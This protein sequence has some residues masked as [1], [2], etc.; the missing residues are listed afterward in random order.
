MK[1]YKITNQ[2]VNDLDEIWTYTFENWSVE[3]AD[4]YYS[5]IIEEI[6]YL[7]E[8]PG[9]GTSMDFIKSGYRSSKV[10][11]HLIFYKLGTKKI[12]EVVRVLHQSMDIKKR[13]E[14]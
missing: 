12:I 14:E 5:L 3:Q 11:S 2:A 9:V 1:N 13:I 10:K 6:E 8:N 4:R 7:A